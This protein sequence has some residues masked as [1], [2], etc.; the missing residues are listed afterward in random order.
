MKVL[1]IN[2]VC[3]VGS[4]GKICQDLYWAL[5]KQGHICKIAW[6]RKK[7]GTVPEA[8]TIQIGTQFDCYLHALST[9]IFDN[10]GFCSQRATEGFIERAKVYD[11]DVIHLH[12][13][14]GYYINIRILFNFL[15]V[16]KK[17]II[18]TLHDCWSFTGHCVH[19]D[20]VGCQKWKTQCFLCP[21]KS[22]YPRS[23]LLDRSYKNYREK[24]ELFTGIEDLHIVTPSFWL[25]G[26]VKE[27]FLKEY[28]VTVVH[29]GIDATVFHPTVSDI[30]KHYGLEERRIVLGVAYQWTARKGYQ[31][32]LRL[33]ALLPKDKYKVVLIGVNE[34]QIKELPRS[35]LGIP[36]V[37][38]QDL[39]KWYS[40]ADVFVNPTYE[41]VFGMVNVEAQLCGT[42]VVSYRTGGCPETKISENCFFL[43]KG[44]VQSMVRLVKQIEPKNPSEINVPDE[45]IALNSG[46]KTGEAR[47]AEDTKEKQSLS[48][49]ICQRGES[50]GY[51]SMLRH[52]VSL[53]LDNLRGGAHFTDQVK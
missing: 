6:G 12:N 37:Q 38:G 1:L 7:G 50:G 39:N 15:K 46:S 49:L 28:P 41:E 16:C 44:D 32:M 29:N 21:Q 33:A 24:K 27:S 8:D 25:E 48:S 2:S 47:D 14:H 30:R 3:G 40:A 35:I 53:Y 45:A 43:E 19:M 5:K 34:K 42:P 51:Q 18:W 17:K 10:T 4:T 26:L 36:R 9:R 22:D 11:P 20:F 52:I 23:L 13:I 31:D